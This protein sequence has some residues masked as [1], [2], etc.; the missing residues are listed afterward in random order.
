M[1]A[2]F[3]RI[4]KAKWIKLDCRNEVF[5][6][7][8]KCFVTLRVYVRFWITA[9]MLVWLPEKLENGVDLWSSAPYIIIAQC[10]RLMQR[11]KLIELKRCRGGLQNGSWPIHTKS[12]KFGE[13]RVEKLRRPTTCPQDII[14]PSAH[15]DGGIFFFKGICY[16]A[17]DTCLRNVFVIA[18][19]IFGTLY[20]LTL[21]I[22]SSFQRFR[23]SVSTEYLAQSC[24]LYFFPE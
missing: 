1:Q 24:K 15:K 12:A 6:F 13:F 3:A 11:R 9:T 7:H 4:S 18:L 5:W 21:Q 14:W 16:V 10:G 2:V 22:F 8:G 17:T 19:L 23:I 20:H